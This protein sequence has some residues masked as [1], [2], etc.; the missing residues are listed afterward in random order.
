MMRPEDCDVCGGR[1]V[2]TLPVVR[3]ISLAPMAKFEASATTVSHRNFPCPE[4]GPQV[5]ENRVKIMEFGA[6]IAAQALGYFGQG[7]VPAE[8]V[9][10]AQRDAARTIH[11]AM[12]QQ[13]LFSFERGPYDRND[14]TEPH[15]ARIGVVAP[16]VVASMEERIAQRQEELARE[17]VNLAGP[18]ILASTTAR[19][20]KLLL[21]AAF[22]TAMDRRA[23]EKIEGPK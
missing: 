11:E 21:D 23:R 18:A 7:G 10:M 15:Y 13:G 20:A 19:E 16:A 3:R 17:V 6:T 12:L 4:C 1:R 2:I 22:K 14:M 8:F 9:A 5:S